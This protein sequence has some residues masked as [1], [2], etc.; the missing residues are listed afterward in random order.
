MKKMLLLSLILMLN[1]FQTEAQIPFVSGGSGSNCSN[2]NPGGMNGGDATGV[3][4][5]GGGAGYYGGNGGKGLYG[6]GGGG[7][8][9]Y[10]TPNQSG[11]KGGDGAIVVAF[12]DASDVLLSANLYSSSGNITIVAGVTS[13]KVWAIGAGGG[14]AGSI[15]SDGTSG[16]GGGAGG[17]AYTT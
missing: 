7:A 14:G 16:G 8:A 10:N 9:G 2:S 3:G 4:C 15:N 13:V 6:G 11:G 17:V 5:G 1:L 12:F